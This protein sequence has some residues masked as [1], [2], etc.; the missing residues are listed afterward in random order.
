MVQS[1]SATDSWEKKSLQQLVE[2]TEK[3][4]LTD[5]K[6]CFVW[7]R[8]GNVPMFFKYKGQLIDLAPK[9]IGKAMQKE[10]NE[11]IAEYLR[12]QLVVG[13]RTGDKILIDM[14]KLNPDWTELHQEGVFHPNLVF[15]REEWYKQENYIK[16]VKEEENYSVGGLNKGMYRLI[17]DS[18]CLNICS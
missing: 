8:N 2:A 1:A 11:S 16:F 18:F 17:D 3:A 4:N 7:D 9:L 12:A 5:K 6:Y 15:N 13:Q 14:G 10:T